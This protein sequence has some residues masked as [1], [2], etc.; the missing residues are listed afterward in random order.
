VEKLKNCKFEYNSVQ[1]AK[2]E[3]TSSLEVI[4]MRVAILELEVGWWS[5]FSG[6]NQCS[7]LSPN[8]KH[9]S[10]G[11]SESLVSLGP[12]LWLNRMREPKCHM[13]L[14]GLQG[15]TK[16]GNAE[17]TIQFGQTLDLK[18]L[19]ASNECENIDG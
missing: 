1:E 3:S 17:I 9:E 5:S 11:V 18:D 15:I 8:S 6:V 4:K 12:G 19:K 7:P 16:F 2:E 10:E 13:L 14:E